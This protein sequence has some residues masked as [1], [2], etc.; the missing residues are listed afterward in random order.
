[1]N[2]IK[3][4]FLKSADGRVMITQARLAI[5]T[6]FNLNFKNS[7]SPNKNNDNIISP[8]K[9]KNMQDLESLDDGSIITE[10]R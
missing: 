4:D 3:N 10:S 1:L 6:Q 9:V 5:A 8:F 7:P 2:N